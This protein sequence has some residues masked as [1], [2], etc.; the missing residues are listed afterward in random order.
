MQE[1][2]SVAFES[3]ELSNVDRWW[4]T[5]EKGMLVVVLCRKMWQ[6]YWERELARSWWFLDWNHYLL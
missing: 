4:P 2:R 1:G 6:H 3:K 5:H